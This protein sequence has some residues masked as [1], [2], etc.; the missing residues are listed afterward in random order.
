MSSFRHDDIAAIVELDNFAHVNRN[1]GLGTSLE[2]TAAKREELTLF[3]SVFQH[4]IILVPTWSSMRSGTPVSIIVT[5]S[6]AA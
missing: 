5:F 6:I 1:A 4:V 3:C 2:N